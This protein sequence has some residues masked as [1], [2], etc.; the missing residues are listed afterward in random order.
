MDRVKAV[1][2]HAYG[3]AEVLCY[4]DIPRPAAG[5]GEVLVRVHAASVNPVDWK[6][7]NGFVKAMYPTPPMAPLGGDLAGVVED[8][9]AGVS[10]FAPGDEVFGMIGLLGAYAEYVV[11][12]AEHLAPKP[13]G[14]DFI[15]AASV[16]LVALTA[17]QAL[18]DTAQLQAGQRILIHAAAGGV[19]SMA[20]QLARW[21]GAHVTG[22]ASPGNAEYLRE[23]GAEAVIDYH[24]TPVAAMPGDFDVVLD[25]AGGDTAERSLQLLK[26]GG[27]VVV[28]AGRPA[29]REPDSQGR[30]LV[31]IFGQASGDTLRQIGTLLDA[32]EIRTEIAA[33]FELEDVA[34]A[35]DLSEQG[36]TRGK[37]VLRMCD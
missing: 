15:N 34:A 2:I 1:R 33:V 12:K 22:T 13:R 30:R 24:Q 5:P 19:G 14:L 8:V 17:W 3:G 7:R 4:E 20:V 32:G 36:H 29:P 37:I 23:I 25:L 16:P 6:I 26:P 18:F 35:H 28:V 11:A 21:K 9:G 10:D 27:I 31:G